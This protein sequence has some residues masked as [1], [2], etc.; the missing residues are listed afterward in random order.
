MWAASLDT[1]CYPRPAACPR[2]E[3]SSQRGD[4]TAGL[5]PIPNSR[6]GFR[7]GL[8]NRCAV[9]AFVAQRSSQRATR[10][11]TRGANRS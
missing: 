9:S 11:S 8:N 5:T 7:S 10:K 4:E 3:D 6:V 1:L 2:H